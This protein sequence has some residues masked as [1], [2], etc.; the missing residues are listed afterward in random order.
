M[1]LGVA[2]TRVSCGLVVARIALGSNSGQVPEGFS[3]DFALFTKKAAS[4][5]NAA[6]AKKRE[7]VR[8]V[9][10]ADLYADL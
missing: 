5:G 4:C 9:N 7:D 2:E 6:K 10:T 8:L 3:H 1:T